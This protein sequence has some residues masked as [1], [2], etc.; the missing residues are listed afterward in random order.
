MAPMPRS[1][2]TRLVVAVTVAVAAPATM[3]AEI[4]L[5][6][7]PAGAATGCQVAY[8]AN[9]W[10]GGFTA[11]VRLTVGEARSGWTL[12]WTWPSGQQ[13]TSAWNARVTQS[14]AEVTAG[15]EAYNGA[16][17]A[18][19][20]VEF[21]LQGTWSAANTA[22]TAFAL[23]GVGC[24]GLGASPSAPASPSGGQSPSGSPSPSSS[25]S[26]SSSSPSAGPSQSSAPPAGCGSAVV[27][28][29]FESQAAGTPAG[30]WSV[31]YPDCS[32]AGT[33]TVDTAVAHGGA[34]SI[35]INGGAGYCNHVF[36]AS[37]TSLASVGQVWYVRL[38]VRHTTALPA[39]HVTFV[40]MPDAADGNRALRLGGQNAALQW[41]RESD[42]ATLPVQSPV[43]VAMSAPL[44]TGAWSCVEYGVS[45]VDGTLRTWLNGAAVA[46]LTEDGVPT[47]DIDQQWLNRTWRPALTTFR[48][49]WESYGGGTDTLWFD[50]IAVGSS[51]IGC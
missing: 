9:Q 47:A 34:R 11:A 42:D 51:R 5:A 27:C 23:D 32:G 21:G 6:D 19:G 14:G 3:A 24:T 30:A 2:R 41:N 33:A 46:G 48:F 4:L 18:G 10:T 35:R 15:N 1:L 39:D 12:T 22:P 36:V 45:G 17:P 40:S 7:A 43:G 25:P 38:Y 29:G 16:V 8:S 26:R 49:G 37:A 44:A 50:D 31:T 20:S 28:D 13:V